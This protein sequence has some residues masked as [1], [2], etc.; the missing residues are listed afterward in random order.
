M[1]YLIE[2]ETSGVTDVPIIITFLTNPPQRIRIPT[3][4]L[5]GIINAELT[6]PDPERIEYKLIE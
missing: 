3:G 2:S 5:L 6:K 4:T 1:H